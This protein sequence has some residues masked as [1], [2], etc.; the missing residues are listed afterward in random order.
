M[1]IA[2]LILLWLSFTS[3]LSLHV[4]LAIAVGKALGPFKGALSLL[5]FPVAPY[6]GLRSGARKRSAAWLVVGTAYVLCL[7]FALR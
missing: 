4:L 7:F 2:L 3:F 1:D 5:A 6:F